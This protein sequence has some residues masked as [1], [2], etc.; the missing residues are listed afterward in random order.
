[1]VVHVIFLVDRG[2]FGRGGALSPML[3]NLVM[4]ALSKMMDR[5]VSGGL[6][7][8]FTVSFGEHSNVRVSYLLFVD[9]TLV[10]C[11]AD[12]AQLTYLKQVLVW[13]QIVSGLKINL[14][15]C[16]IILVGEVEN[17]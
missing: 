9:D 8:A 10:F 3:F 4:E 16:E 1:M 15:K 13:F 17:I 11:D 7:R 5:A 6:L 12:V 14:S 2:D